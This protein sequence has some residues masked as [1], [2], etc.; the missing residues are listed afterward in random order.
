MGV[1]TASGTSP[2]LLKRLSGS[3]RLNLDDEQR[4]AQGR[5]L[6]REAHGESSG[7]DS[8]GALG[9]NGV[10]RSLLSMQTEESLWT[11][12]LLSPAACFGIAR[13]FVIDPPLPPFML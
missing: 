8:G 3:G 4:A 10:E 9:E 6:K 1:G 5:G 13:H 11:E 2:A 7:G 12:K